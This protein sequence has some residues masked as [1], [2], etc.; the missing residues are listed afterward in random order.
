MGR[1][2]ETYISHVPQLIRRFSQNTIQKQAS[3]AV[4]SRR[5]RLA[6]CFGHFRVVLNGGGEGC[7][8]TTTTKRITLYELYGSGK[9]GRFRELPD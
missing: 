8:F 4:L 9:R 7:I 6:L 5:T 1:R 3:S 2:A